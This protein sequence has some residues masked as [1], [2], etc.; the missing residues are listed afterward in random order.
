[1]TDPATLARRID[2][3]MG[4][5][6][7]DL[8]IR[9]ARLLDVATGTVHE[10]ADLAVCGDT[11]VGTLG[12]WR[13]QRESQRWRIQEAEAQARG[14]RQRCSEGEETERREERGER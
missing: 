14:W 7:A 3:A 10:P 11:I 5:E 4:R 1:M 13:G 12:R 8:V 9:D 6:P 2:Q